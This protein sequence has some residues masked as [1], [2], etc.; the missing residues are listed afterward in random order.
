V[1]ELITLTPSLIVGADEMQSLQTSYVALNNK[2]NVISQI[3]GDLTYV[4][5]L[6]FDYRP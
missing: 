1:L 6:L 5:E 4:F 3:S 2:R